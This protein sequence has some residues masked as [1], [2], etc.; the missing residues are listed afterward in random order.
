MATRD[1]PYGAFNFMVKLGDTG[2]EDQIAGGFSTVSGL[3]TEIEYAEY[4]NGNDKESHVHKIAG[5]SRVGDV[6]LKRGLIGDL[7]LFG[8]LKAVRDGSYDPRTV[9]ITLLD[10]QRNPVCSWVLTRAQPKRWVGPA[11]NAGASGHV[12]ME[13]LHLVTERIDFQST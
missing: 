5:L 3:D 10:E 8:W 6:T 7:R 13:E 11:L 12:A 4:R 1:N 2:G 9:T